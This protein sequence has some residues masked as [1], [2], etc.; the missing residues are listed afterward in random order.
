MEA[1]ATPGLAVAAG[2]LKWPA[3]MTIKD[4]LSPGQTLTPTGRTGQKAAGTAQAFLQATS[5][6]IPITLWFSLRQLLFPP[7]VLAEKMPS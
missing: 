7:V 1:A 6:A 2:S 4:T 3:F 5:P